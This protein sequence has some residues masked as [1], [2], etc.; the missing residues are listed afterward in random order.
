MEN[1]LVSPEKIN[2]SLLNRN[3]LIKPINL[4]HPIPSVSPIVENNAS[5][6]TTPPPNIIVEETPIACNE[7]IVMPDVVIIDPVPVVTHIEPIA[8]NI[9]NN[10]VRGSSRI[11]V[12]SPVLNPTITRLRTSSI[13][14]KGFYKS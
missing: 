14:P 2:S 1:L 7:P 10:T 5:E 12:L 8:N 4:N 13:K 3:S 6:P 9:S 11:P